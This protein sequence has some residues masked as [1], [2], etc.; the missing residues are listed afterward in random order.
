MVN[1]RYLL[2]ANKVTSFMIERL[3]HNC[4]KTYIILI[5]I[6]INLIASKKFRKMFLDLRGAILSA[7]LAS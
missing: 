4:K 3:L 5:D 1:K 7:Q 2:A 6:K